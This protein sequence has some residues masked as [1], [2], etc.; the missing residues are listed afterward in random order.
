M[1][2]PKEMASKFGA[3]GGELMRHIQQESGA[4][5]DLSVSITG[6]YRDIRMA[7]L[8]VNDR[9]ICFLCSLK[10]YS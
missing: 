2:I 9:L 6:S 10:V 4:R 8:L 7:Q 3:N 1:T 5:V